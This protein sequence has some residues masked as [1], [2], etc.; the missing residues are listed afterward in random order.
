V[1]LDHPVYTARPAIPDEPLKASETALLV[2]D[3]QRAVADPEF[4]LGRLA[5]EKGVLEQSSWYYESIRQALPRMRLLQ[6]ACRGAGIEVLFTRIQALSRDG[7]DL[8]PGYRIGGMKV[9]RGSPEA[10][11]LPQ[12]RPVGD[13]IVI[14]KT[15]S[16]AFNSSGIDHTLRN[17]GVRQLIVC[18][19]ATHGCVEL[20][21]RDADDRGYW[22]HVASDACAAATEALHRNSLERMAKGLT[23]IRTSA[24]IVEMIRAAG[25]SAARAS[26]GGRR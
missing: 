6:D 15:S 3:V 10:E 4:G 16:S 18:G 12:V 5:R 7:R 20:T 17:L 2:V 21:C 19:I 13:E 24:E 26:M 9:G 1:A 11:I 22:V 25:E 14:D 23:R 8:M